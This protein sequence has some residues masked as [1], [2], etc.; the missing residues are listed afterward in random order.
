[1]ITKGQRQDDKKRPALTLT[2]TYRHKD[3]SNL[4]SFY[5]KVR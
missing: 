1:M 3:E 4:L 5:N 2:V